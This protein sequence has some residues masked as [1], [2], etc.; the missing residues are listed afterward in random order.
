MNNPLENFSEGVNFWD[1]NPQYKIIFKDLYS[2][3]KSKNKENSSRIM[4][5]VLFLIHPKSDFYNLP[6]KEELLVKDFIKIKDFKWSD[7]QDLISIARDMFL[8]QAERS[9]AN[10]EEYMKK[11]DDYLKNTRYYFDEYLTDENGENVLSK[12]GREITIKGTAEQLDKAW[13]SSKAMWSDYRTIQ[14]EMKVEDEKKGKGNKMLSMG[15]G[16]DL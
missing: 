12:T 1:F 6:N 11:R 5:G 9:M 14:K 2:K 4:W 13:L 15:D 3:D 7:Y 16:G 8:S 10:W